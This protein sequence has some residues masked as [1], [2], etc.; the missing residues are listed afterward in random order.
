MEPCP[1]PN[2]QETEGATGNL[3]TPAEQG[4]T[5]HHLCGAGGALWPTPRCLTRGNSF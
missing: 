5:G 1:S 2:T 4:R 3:Q